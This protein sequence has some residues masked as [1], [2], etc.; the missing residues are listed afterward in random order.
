MLPQGGAVEEPKDQVM[1]RVLPGIPG[2]HIYEDTEVRP[3]VVVRPGP[4]PPPPDVPCSTLY[5]HGY[6]SVG[7][8]E[9]APTHPLSLLL[10][11]LSQSPC[12]AKTIIGLQGQH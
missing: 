12:P 8:E 4:H 10:P 7:A 3:Q 1:I 9:S 2:G 11:R 6:R 5:C